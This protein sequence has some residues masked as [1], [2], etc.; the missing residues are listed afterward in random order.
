ML[1]VFTDE[2]TH[3]GGFFSGFGSKKQEK[4]KYSWNK[5]IGLIKVFTGLQNWWN[6]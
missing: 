1:G 3:S 5:H 2:Q 6:A 4:C